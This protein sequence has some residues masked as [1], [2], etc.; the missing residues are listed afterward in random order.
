MVN[1]LTYLEVA[2]RLWLTNNINVW[3]SIQLSHLWMLIWRTHKMSKQLKR[4]ALP[5]EKNEFCHLMGTHGLY[6]MLEAGHWL[7]HLSLTKGLWHRYSYIFIWHRRTERPRGWLPPHPR[8]HG[9]WIDH[10]EQV[11]FT[12]CPCPFSGCQATL[13][14]NLDH[15]HQ[16][17]WVSLDLH[18]LKWSH[19]CGSVFLSY[20]EPR[21][22]QKWPSQL[23][24]NT[25]LSFCLSG[26]HAAET[27]LATTY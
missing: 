2:I 15:T 21:F 27:K 18:L 20:S 4:L 26:S 16:G 11:W 25:E 6:A 7:F 23:S 19:F 22:S 5:Q 1:W 10:I 8:T 17:V 24:V 9:L 14:E 12:V 13:S 3:E